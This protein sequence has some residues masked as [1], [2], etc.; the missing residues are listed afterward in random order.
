MMKLSPKGIV[1]GGLVD[2]ALSVVIGV[3]L[4]LYVVVSRGLAVRDERVH[5]AIAAAIQ[6]SIWLY[7]AQLA[8][9][10]ACSVL[11]GYVA[12]GIARHDK[13]VNGILASWLCVGIG[14]SCLFAV[15]VPGSWLP[16]VVCIAITPL[17]YLLGAFLRTK[18]T[19]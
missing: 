19:Q 6:S 4:S 12:A 14:E 17:W 9:G 1:I 18:R 5:A 11:G 7:S 8:T 10:V 16:R 2:V 13:L 3:A 15:T